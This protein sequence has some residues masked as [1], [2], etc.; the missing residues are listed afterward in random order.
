MADNSVF[1][2]GVADGA[3]ESALGDLPPWATQHTAESIETILRKTL[4]LQTKAL[5]QLVKKAT[6]GDNSPDAK[7][8]RK[9]VV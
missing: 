6:S 9:S 7:G 5:S 2:T 4:S 8:D 3:F 1:I